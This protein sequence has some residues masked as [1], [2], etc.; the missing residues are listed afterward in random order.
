MKIWIELMVDGA[1]HTWW[2]IYTIHFHKIPACLNDSFS[3]R[4]RSSKETEIE[5]D[6]SGYSSSISKVIVQCFS[7]WIWIIFSVWRLNSPSMQYRDSR[8]TENRNNECYYLTLECS[9]VISSKAHNA[10]RCLYCLILNEC[11]TKVWQND[12]KIIA[13]GPNK[14]APLRQWCMKCPS[15][16]I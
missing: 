15:V 1:G 8:T 6:D 9:T 3:C 13:N 7:N 5:G 12:L 10:L 11:N 16:G 2:P 4:G 14:N